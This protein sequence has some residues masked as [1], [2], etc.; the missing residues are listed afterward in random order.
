MNICKGFCCANFEKECKNKVTHKI[1]DSCGM[2]IHY[3]EKHWNDTP[4]LS[5]E[6]RDMPIE[7]RLIQMVLGLQSCKTK[8]DAKEILRE[9]YQMG[10]EDERRAFAERLKTR[11]KHLYPQLEKR[12]VWGLSGDEVCDNCEDYVMKVIDEE[13]KK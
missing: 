7:F 2:P 6:E 9:A 11:I 13:A 4:Y 8:E 10:R 12:S 1:I 5:K 3:C